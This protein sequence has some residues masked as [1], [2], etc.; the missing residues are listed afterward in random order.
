MTECPRPCSLCLCRSSQRH[1]LGSTH[2]KER[3]S[4]DNE[5]K[6]GLWLRGGGVK[7]GIFLLF[8]NPLWFDPLFS[9]EGLACLCSS[10]KL[11]RHFMPPGV[12]RSHLKPNM[13]QGTQNLPG[14]EGTRSP[15]QAEVPASLASLLLPCS[16]L[17]PGFSLPISSSAPHR[18]AV[19]PS[20]SSWT[21]A[22]VS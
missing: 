18:Q 13:S 16:S 12:S 3:F 15:H 20:L 11:E 5:D 4:K 22:R 19:G 2:H 10:T 1:S 6:C 8:P 17:C 7:K 14:K 21:P 9:K